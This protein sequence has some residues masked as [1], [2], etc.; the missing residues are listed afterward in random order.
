MVFFA[1]YNGKA[2]TEAL[3]LGKRHIF[4]SDFSRTIGKNIRIYRRAS[5]M[6]LEALAEKIHK[7]KATVGKYEQGAIAVDVDTLRDIARALDV[8]PAQLLS[9]TVVTSE[10][11]DFVRD[12]AHGYLYLYDGRMGRVV[13]S[14]LLTA[15]DGDVSLFYDIPSFDEPQHCRSLY[16]GRRQTHDFVTNFLLDNRLSGVEHLFLCMMRSLDRPTCSTGLLSGISS[17]MFLPAC[18]K[19]VLSSEP[20][21]EN[22]ELRN[23]LLLSKDDLKI[24]RRYNMFMVEQAGLWN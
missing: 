21:P 24:I 19:C 9:E 15:E 5:R 6:T 1:S 17:R 7:S 14:L 10:T 18:A 11:A 3:I 16:C 20:L 22:D 2:K 4:M 8:S 23:S 12:G 13:K